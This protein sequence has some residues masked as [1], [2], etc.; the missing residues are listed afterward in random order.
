MLCDWLPPDFGAVG[1]Y[2]EQFARTLAAQGA[3][4]TLI[5]FSSSSESLSS[6][7]VGA[8]SLTIRRLQIAQY[9]RSA[10]LRRSLWTLH[11]N[12]ALVF[13]AIKVL[14]GADE[15]QFT[16]SPPY[17]IHFILPVAKLFGVRTRYRITDFHPEC[18][19]AALKRTPLSIRL[20]QALTNFW[21]RHVDVIEVL[22]E[23]QR[24]RLRSAR[25]R[26]ERIELRRDGSPVQFAGDILPAATPPALAGRKIILY[27][28]NWGVAHDHAT[29]VAGFTRFCAHHPDVA[30]LWMNA[31]GKRADIVEQDLRARGL[32]YA[33]TQPV[34][35]ESLAAVL[36]AADV[37]LIALEDRFVGLVLPSKVYA[38]V[39]S[40]RSVL[41][42]GSEASDVDLI[43][44][45][46]LPAH[47]YQRVDV[48]DPAGV[49]AALCEL[50]HLPLPA[51]AGPLQSVHQRGN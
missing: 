35:L 42:V 20:L 5:G 37:H 45:Q 40:G 4:V 32:P 50:L 21:R 43:C 26:A 33:R 38:C 9:D 18:L 14:R 11:A 23:D 27:S 13:A 46:G 3:A 28:G 39:A 44:R 36:L 17:L 41:F 12:L 34:A 30:G 24:R 29:F 15:V 7:N 51:V 25:V 47:R 48:N 19:I 8:G 31:T 16:G 1:Q 49:E 6:Q 22:G 2:A 10:L